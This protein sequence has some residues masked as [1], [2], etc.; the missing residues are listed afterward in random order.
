VRQIARGIDLCVLA[1]AP[2]DLKRLCH[3]LVSALSDAG[4]PDA[5]VVARCVPALERYGDT[6]K[7]R[8]FIPA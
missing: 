1:E 5:E 7:L 6:G 3:E 4:L 8:R 2:H